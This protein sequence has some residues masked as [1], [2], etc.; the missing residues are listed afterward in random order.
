MNSD[1]YV[2]KQKTKTPIPYKNRHEI[3]EMVRICL[4]SVGIDVFVF[5]TQR[6][7]KVSHYYKLLSI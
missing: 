4:N 5:N 1:M 6:T 7:K 2:K 3:Q